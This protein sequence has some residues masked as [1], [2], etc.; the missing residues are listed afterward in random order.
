MKKDNKVTCLPNYE[1][2]KTKNIVTFCAFILLM[3][4]V[5]SHL[6]YSFYTITQNLP[7]VL[8]RFEEGQ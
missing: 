3:I 5:I 7:T 8:D 6:G 1:E 2:N 4:V